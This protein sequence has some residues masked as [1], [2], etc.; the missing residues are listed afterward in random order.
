MPAAHVMALLV[1][2]AAL[3][4]GQIIEFESGGLK[5]KTLT[6]NGLTV[7]F[8]HLPNTVRDYSI[9]QVA[10]SNGSNKPCAVRPEDFRYER[11]DGVILAPT[12]PRAVIRELIEKAG[13][14]DVIRLVATYEIGLYGL[15]RLKS[16]NGYEQR[17][18]AAFAELTSAKLKAAAAASAI[19]FVP[20]LLKPGESTDGAIFFANGGRPLGPGKLILQAAGANFEFPSEAGAP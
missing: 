12:E 13:R 18:Q 2:A 7:M 20:V 3:L 1:G 11:R 8:A 4:R 10:L 5:Y 14:G 9:I 19:A 17:R 6:R 15:T 16:T